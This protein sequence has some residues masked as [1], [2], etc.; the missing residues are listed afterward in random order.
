MDEELMNLGLDEKIEKS[1]EVINEAL[2]KF[3]KIAVAFTGGKDSRSLDHKH[4]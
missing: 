4:C 2:D 1:K 3:E